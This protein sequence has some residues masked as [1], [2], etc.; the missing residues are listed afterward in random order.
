MVIPNSVSVVGEGAFGG[1]ESL[2]NIV[3]SN[4]MIAI[5]PRMCISCINLRN[6]VI[7]YGIKYIHND[8]FN[9]CTSLTN[10]RFEGTMNEWN[11]ITKKTDWNKNV[12]ATEVVCSD[13]TVSLV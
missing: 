4:N 11:N 7:P 8:V 12:P 10:I 13:G 5:L 1:C 3:F 6:V 2:V 9:G